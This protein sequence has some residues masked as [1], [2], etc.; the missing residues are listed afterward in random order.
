VWKD[1]HCYDLKGGTVSDKNLGRRFRVPQWQYQIH[2]IELLQDA[3]FDDEVEKVLEEYGARG[4]ELGQV[5]HRHKVPE[6][7]SGVV[8]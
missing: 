7:P 5:L 2:L 4:W 6:E 1:A 8:P 3:D